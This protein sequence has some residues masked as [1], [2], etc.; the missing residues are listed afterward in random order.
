VETLEVVGPV[1]AAPAIPVRSGRALLVDVGST[2]TKVAVLD[3]AARR[4]VA[5]AHAR[6][7]IEHDVTEGVAAAV[8]A[9]PGDVGAPFDW[10][11]S[12]SSAA[13]GLRMVSVGLTAALS[14]RAGAL[15]ALGAGA[16]VVATE[17]GYVDDGALERIRAADP[18]LLLLSG[19]LDGGNAD[20]L[21][22]NARAL[23]RLEGLAG[24]VVA[25]NAAA[26]R[27]AASELARPDRDVRIVDNVFPRPAELVVGPTREVVRDLFLRHIT[28][29]K[30]LDDLLR[31]LQAEC[32]PTPLAV[33]RG[34]ALLGD[35]DQPVVLVD[36][37]GATTDVHSAGGRQYQRGGAELPAPEVARTVEGDLGMRWGAPGIVAAMGDERR[38]ALGADLGVDLVAEADRRHG[39]PGYLPA[40]ER[41]RR[42]D[43]ALAREAVAVALERHAGRVVVRH[44]P[45]GDRYRVTGTDLRGARLLLGTGGVFRHLPDPER[46]LRAAL[47][48]ASA[49]VPRD[50]AAGVDEHYALYA[51]GLLARVDAALAGDVAGRLFPLPSGRTG[52]TGGCHDRDA[53]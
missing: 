18:H 39:D 4:I 44:R 26:A 12:C 7:T 46:L 22:H 11:L 52:R 35:A 48:G 47:E 34:M 31:Q 16:R 53:G 1:P 49:L 28:R 37:G 42:T 3:V 19:G 38:A 50:P 51:I 32:E 15:A 41:G 24:V 21:I 6:T 20:A 23:Q 27:A 45:W 13:G 33:S 8:A 2:F 5:H 30:G 10:A 14:G 25:G 17:A 40:D 36:V 43:A 29:A 9:L